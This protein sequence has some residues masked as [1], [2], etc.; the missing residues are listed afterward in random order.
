SVS[1][2]NVSGNAGL[3]Q[4]GDYVDMILV[5]GGS[6]SSGSG[7]FAGLSLPSK[8][9]AVVSE[10]IV[11]KARV[12]AVGSV[13]RQAIDSQGNPEDGRASAGPTISVEVRTRAAEAANLAQ[14]LG[15][16][17][18]ALRSRASTDAHADRDQE[19]GNV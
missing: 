5:Q 2:D 19:T 4:P 6:S 7:P 15:T 10:T 3:I 12:I 9:Q 13:F 11:Q 16:V 17:P 18:L 1:V 8:A 14:R